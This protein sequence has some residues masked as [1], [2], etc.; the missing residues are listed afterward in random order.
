MKLKNVLIGA[1]VAF[2]L[3]KTFVAREGFMNMTTTNIIVLSVGVILL[4]G[5]VVFMIP[6]ML[7]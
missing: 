6:Q 7:Q 4:V 3:Y 1:L 5:L 2:V